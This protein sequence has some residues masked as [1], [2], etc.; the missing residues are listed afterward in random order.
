MKVVISANFFMDMHIIYV[1]NFFHMSCQLLLCLLLSLWF[2]SFLYK[3]FFCRFAYMLD[4]NSLRSIM[5]VCV[6]R[7]T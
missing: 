6:E 1:S 5:A 7:T 4:D 2:I 3:F